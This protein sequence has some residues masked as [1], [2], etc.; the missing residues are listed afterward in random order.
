MNSDTSPKLAAIATISLPPVIAIAVAFMAGILVSHYL[1]P[2]DTVVLAVLGL[3]LAGAI[4]GV[5]RRW[6]LASVLL[7]LL[8]WSVLGVLSYHVRYQRSAENDI[9]RYS[10][11]KPVL[12][13]VR[14]EVLDD[15]RWLASDSPWPTDSSLHLPVRVSQIHTR[16]A[17][18]SASGLLRVQGDG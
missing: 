16:R 10:C 5:V 7:I 11:E 17:W 13:R 2:P 18:T 12:V 3:S 4:G 6:K 1:A 15:S 8:A 9:V 14:A